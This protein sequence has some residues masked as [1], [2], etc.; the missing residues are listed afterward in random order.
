VRQNAEFLNA[1]AGGTRSYH[2]ALNGQPEKQFIQ[3]Y[4]E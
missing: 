2:W 1:A 3:K 4:E